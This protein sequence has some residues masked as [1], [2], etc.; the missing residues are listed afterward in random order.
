MLIRFSFMANHTTRGN[1]TLNYQ[2]IPY[3]AALLLFDE[4]PGSLFYFSGHNFYDW[5]L[6]REE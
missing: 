4:G 6:K 2:E 3:T 1:D 5:R